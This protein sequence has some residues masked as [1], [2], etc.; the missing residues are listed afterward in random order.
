MSLKVK[1]NLK[2]TLP[3]AILKKER[4]V[5][6]G[7]LAHANSG[8]QTRSIVHLTQSQKAQASNVPLEKGKKCSFQTIDYMSEE[9]LYVPG[10]GD[11]NAGE[12]NTG[13]RYE[14][15]FE[16]M[17]VDDHSGSELEEAVTEEKHVQS[18]SKARLTSS[19]SL[20]PIIYC[21]MTDTSIIL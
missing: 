18:A 4:S 3:S 11:P 19:V 17:E 16:G 7:I 15:G 2:S 20:S 9:E 10:H 5:D 13:N 12:D 21:Q 1:N 6:F 14:E 8:Q